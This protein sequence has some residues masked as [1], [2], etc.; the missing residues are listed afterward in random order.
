MTDRTNVLIVFLEKDLRIDDDAEPLIN[1]IKQLRG[2]LDVRENVVD[3][4][5]SCAEMRAYA[6]V[7]ERLLKIVRDWEP[8]F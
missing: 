3:M 8:T 6:S 2:V 7:R 4:N 1:S 5:A